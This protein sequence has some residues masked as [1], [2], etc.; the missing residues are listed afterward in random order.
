[1]RTLA[2]TGVLYCTL[3][4]VAYAA[5]H[6]QTPNYPRNITSTG[7]WIV[8]GASSLPDGAI[9]F[10]A[11]KINPY[12][13]NLA[14]IGLTK[15]KKYYPQ[16]KAWMQ[17][18]IGHLNEADRWGL[19]CTMYDY[20]VAGTEESPLNDAD[21]TD[22]YAASFL[23]LAW[24]FWQTGDAS[25]QAY[26]RTLSNQLDCIGGVIVQT[27]QSNGLTWAKPDYQIQFLMDNTEVYRGLRDAASLFEA[28][29]NTNARD[30][31]DAHAA[32][33]AE[34][35]N[36]DLWDAGNTS[37][38]T[39]VGAPPT[40]WTIWYPD[41]TA[42]LFPVLHNLISPADPRAQ[43]LYATFNQKWPNWTSRQ[44]PDPFPWVLVSGASALMGDTTR[45]NQYI[46]TIEDD[47]VDQGFPWT[48][49]SAEAGWFIRVNNY[50]LRSRHA[51][52]FRTGCAAGDGDS[53]FC[54]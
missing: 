22:S 10:T 32:A 45:V 15:N 44:F 28:L 33:V 35:I 31:Y 27:Q 29:Q 2:E 37:Y 36:A 24:A 19:N 9:L 1:M 20:S 16:V 8:S 25:A 41:S 17:W 7:N 54:F 42:Q 34:G 18:Y 3:L 38:L 53:K 39:Y 49:Y 21:S 47:F 11:D 52:G 48:W 14:A 46:H 51:A 12:F 50:M 30:W 6:A 4:V 23:S 40:D 43:Q 13:S 5:C 26:I